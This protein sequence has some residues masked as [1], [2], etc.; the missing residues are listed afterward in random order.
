MNEHQAAN[1]DRRRRTNR[2]I[3]IV[4]GVLAV[5]F[6]LC[7]GLGA[8]VGDPE[9]SEEISPTTTEVAAASPQPST[10]AVEP[11]PAPPVTATVEAPAP[12][13]EAPSVQPP[14]P[15]PVA[16]TYHDPRCGTASETV[17][18]M[19]AAGLT[20][21]GLTLTNGT[22]VDNGI[23]T[24]VGATTMKPTGTME[25][26]ADVW[27]IVDGVVYASSGGA[28]RLTLFPKAPYGKGIAPGDELVALTDECVV[29]LTR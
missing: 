1:I 21:D 26:R 16:G 19:I 23:A 22:V 24:Y 25:S 8:L 3:L 11:P 29:D 4:I 2:N 10:A 28:R 7:A 6:L 18:A 13:P 20:E 27:T 15:T 12:T 14:P 5:S 17:I 9:A